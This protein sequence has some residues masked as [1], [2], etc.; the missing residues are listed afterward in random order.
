MNQVS[1]NTKRRLNRIF[2]GNRRGYEAREY[3][4][5]DVCREAYPRGFLAVS[6]GSREIE[7][8]VSS[9]M[10]SALGE[11]QIELSEIGVAIDECLH[12]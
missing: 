5:H 3:K 6:R 10:E 11:P 8:N 9:Q 12:V 7:H 2:L 1:N 4:A